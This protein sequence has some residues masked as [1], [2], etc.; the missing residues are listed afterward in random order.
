[1]DI[2]TLLKGQKCS[3]GKHH[4]CDI[5]YVS[6]GKGAISAL[7]EMT[8]EYTS[9]LLVADENTYRAAGE[10]VLEAKKE[11]V[12]LKT[13]LIEKE[14]PITVDKDSFAVGKEIRDIFWP[15]GTFI[16]SVKKAPDSTSLLSEGDTLLVRLTTYDEEKTI[17]ELHE[18]LKSDI[19]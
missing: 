18:I 11:A 17:K 15:D 6:I 19:D 9:I 10:K 4:V 2:N 1:M 7:E 8:K 12:I 5:K 13:Q 3:C 14:I 16:L